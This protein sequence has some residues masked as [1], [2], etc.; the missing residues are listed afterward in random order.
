M[1]SPKGE[2]S[3]TTIPPVK[4]IAKVIVPTVANTH[5]VTDVPLTM[6]TKENTPLPSINHD[7]MLS[8]Q[9]VADKYPKLLVCSKVPTLAVKL[10]KEACFGAE[11]MSYC[12]FKAVCSTTNRETF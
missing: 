9:S 2:S 5:S 10:A 1:A 6:T 4:T 8:P 7:Q 12:S 3:F 11:I